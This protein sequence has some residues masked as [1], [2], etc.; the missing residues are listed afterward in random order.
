MDQGGSGMIGLQEMLLQTDGKEIRILLSWPKEWKVD[1]KL[2][3]PYSTTV[4][5]CY[6][7]K[8]ET[9]EVFPPRRKGDVIIK[10]RIK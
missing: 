3:A 1:F 6:N 7:G 9:V 8:I 2:H 10:N 4:K 5:A